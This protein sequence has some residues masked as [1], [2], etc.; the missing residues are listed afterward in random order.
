MDV[1][2]DLGRWSDLLDDDGLR[3]EDIGYLV[4]K[5][6]DVL[7]LA[8]ELTSGLDVLALLWLQEWFDEHL[9]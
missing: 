9:A 6:D 4:G 8:R 2:H 3:G 1:S 5:F 7:S